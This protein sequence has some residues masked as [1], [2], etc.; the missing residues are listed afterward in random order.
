MKTVFF[1]E[2]PNGARYLASEGKQ[3]DILQEISKEDFEKEFPE[4][5]LYNLSFPILLEN[6]AVLL[7]SEWNGEYYLSDGSEY[8]PIYKEVGDDVEII[9]Y[10][11]V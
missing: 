4:K 3:M 1:K 9:G 2:A 5:S 11:E 7:D 10:Y 8:A 6:G